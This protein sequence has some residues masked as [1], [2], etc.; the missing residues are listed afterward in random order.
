VTDDL[1]TN[2]L[3]NPWDTLPAY[4]S[5]EVADV[6]ASSCAGG[7]NLIQNCNFSNG[8]TSWDCDFGGGAA[9]SCSVVNGELQTVITNPGTAAYQ[10]QPNQENLT[11]TQ[12]LTYTVSFSAR[13]SV[14]RSMT[15]SVSMNHTPWSS[16]S[17]VR[18]F[19]ITTGMA[20]YSFTFAMN[21]ASDSNVKFEFGLGAQGNNTVYIDNV[22][23]R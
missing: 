20:T 19:N 15:V 1:L 9:G 11:L 17:G 12:G 21:A 13:A 6:A 18:T 16:Y 14:A 5:A 22:A 10:V 2:G 23:L 7:G 3:L 4:W 8:M